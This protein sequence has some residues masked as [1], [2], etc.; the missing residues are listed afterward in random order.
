MKKMSTTAITTP[1][2][3]PNRPRTDAQDSILAQMERDRNRIR[4]KAR[5]RVM[6]SEIQ[7][8]KPVG[9]IELLVLRRYPRRTVK[10]KAWSGSLAAACGRDETGL[11]GL[12]LWGDQVDRVRSGDI[13]RIEN[14]WCRMS[15]GQKVVSTGRTGR[16]TVLAA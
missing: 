6:V 3:L 14:G 9:R 12:V 7:T 10:T 13:I 11:V 1:R 15:Q 16:L 2:P 4:S 5:P 8:G